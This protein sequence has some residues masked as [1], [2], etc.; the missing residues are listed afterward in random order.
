MNVL[1]NKL[2]TGI[3]G[4]FPGAPVSL[5]AHGSTPGGGKPDRKTYA[6]TA[7]G[8]KLLPLVQESLDVLMDDPDP[9]KKIRA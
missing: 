3:K 5:N 2:I 1:L 9:D 8:K 4:A 7:E 6:S